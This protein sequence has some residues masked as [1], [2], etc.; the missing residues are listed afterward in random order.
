L[1]GHLPF[2]HAGNNVDGWEL[3][4]IDVDDY[5]DKHGA[6]QLAALEAELGPLPDTVMSS[7]RWETAP[8][9]GTRIFLVPKGYRYKGKAFATNHSGPKHIDTIHA[10]HRY[11]VVWPSI[12]PTGAVYEF[13]WGRPGEA[14]KMYTGVPPMAD[15]AVL[16]EKWFRHLE[17]GESNGADARSDMD[18]GE[19]EAWADATFRECQGDPCAA[20]VAKLAEY[21]AGLDLS[22]SHH[23]LNTVVW[24]FTKKAL[25][26]HSGWHTVVNEYLTYW[27]DLSLSKRTADVLNAEAMRSVDG[28]LAKAKAEFDG[29]RHGYMPDD[30]CVGGAGDTD[31]W[32]AKVDAIPEPT[33]ASNGQPSAPLH[34]AKAA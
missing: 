18:F 30:T 11:L 22:D 19:L 20:M 21:K 27:R 14:L 17:A 9:A 24:S 12:H 10:G 31:A 25:E 3:I 7:A 33:A 8:M 2:S 32:A 13:R 6:E 1:N 29:A 4:G 34:R 28:A 5:G 15:V 23:P 16:P 26:G